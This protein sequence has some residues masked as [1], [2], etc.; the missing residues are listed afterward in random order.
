MLGPGCPGTGPGARPQPAVDLRLARSHPQR[1]PVN[2]QLP[3]HPSD[4]ALPFPSRAWISNTIFTARSRSSAGYFGVLPL[5]WIGGIA[6]ASVAAA[7][8]TQASY[9]PTRRATRSGRG[10]A[11]PGAG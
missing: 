5:C 2:A 11:P 9:G 7:R 1:L 3:G 4:L 6:M 8:R 10:A